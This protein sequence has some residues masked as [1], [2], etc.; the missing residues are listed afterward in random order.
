[1]IGPV[2]IKFISDWKIG[3]AADT[4]E[5]IAIGRTKLNENARTGAILDE[6]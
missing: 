4:V 2:K 3:Y 1:M 6:K 5:Q